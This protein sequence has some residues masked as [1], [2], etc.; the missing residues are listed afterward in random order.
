MKLRALCNLSGR[1]GEHDKGATFDVSDGE[2]A[3]VLIKE[4]LAEKV[5]SAA[6]KATATGDQPADPKA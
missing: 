4:G 1:P 3:A 6:K 5:E 2:Y